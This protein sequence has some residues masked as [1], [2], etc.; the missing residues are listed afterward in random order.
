VSESFPGP[1]AR[2]SGVWLLGSCYVLSWLNTEFNIKGYNIYIFEDENEL[3]CRIM[4][5]FIEMELAL[6]VCSEQYKS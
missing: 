5:F 4:V 1:R 6:S 3:E 2:F